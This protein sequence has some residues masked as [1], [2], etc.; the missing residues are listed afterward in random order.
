MLKEAQKLYFIPVDA[1][2]QELRDQGRERELEDMERNVLKGE[3]R[4]SDEE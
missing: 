2:G 1:H 3:G 4:C